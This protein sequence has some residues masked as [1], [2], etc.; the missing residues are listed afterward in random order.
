MECRADY[1]RP[2]Y[3]VDWGLPGK[4]FGWAVVA[5]RGDA[6]EC[7]DPYTEYWGLAAPVNR[8]DDDD[9]VRPCAAAAAPGPCAPLVDTVVPRKASGMVDVTELEPLTAVPLPRQLASAETD[10]LALEVTSILSLNRTQEMSCALYITNYRLKFAD[11][12][13]ESAC[14]LGNSR[15]GGM[16]IRRKGGPQ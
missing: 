2:A 10:R 8:D 7:A 1:K 16:R 9:T 6:D 15:T 12:V 4:A 14:E 3:V 13:T 11:L 5:L